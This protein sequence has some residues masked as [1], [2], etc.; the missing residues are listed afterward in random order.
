MLKRNCRRRG[1]VVFGIGPGQRPRNGLELSVRLFHGHIRLQTTNDGQEECASRLNTRACSIV[2]RRPYLDTLAGKLKA[3]GHD[4]HDP[5][6][7]PIETNLLPDDATI[8]TEA[9]LPQPITK[10]G[11]F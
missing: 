3:A 10:N 8:T 5:V 2:D 4:A 6:W 7:L 11:D 1:I 9:P